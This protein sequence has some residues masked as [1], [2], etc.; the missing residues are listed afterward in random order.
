MSDE[1]SDDDELRLGRLLTW[2]V[3]ANGDHTAKLSISPALDLPVGATFDR[4]INLG[5]LSATSE[6]T[7]YDAFDPQTERRVTITLFEMDRG[8]AADETRSTKAI[9]RR[10]QAASRVRHPHVVEVLDVGTYPSGVFVVTEHLDAI[11]VREWLHQQ[12]PRPRWSRVAAVFRDAGRGLAAAHAHG[13]IHCALTLDDILMTPGGRVCIGG[14]GVHAVRLGPTQASPDPDDPST[15]DQTDELQPAVIATQRFATRSRVSAPEC[16]LGN[17]PSSKSDQFSFCVCFYEALYG[18]HPFEGPNPVTGILHHQLRPQPNPD[19]VPAWLRAVVVHGLAPTPQERHRSMEALLGELDH[20]PV[21]SRR[22]WLKGLTLLAALVALATTAALLI[23]RESTRCEP[24]PMDLDGVWDESIRNRLRTAFQDSGRPYADPSWQTVERRLDDWTAEWQVL[25]ARACELT[26]IRRE[27]SPTLHDRR[28]ACLDDRLREVEAFTH[29]IGIASPQAIEGAVVALEALNRPSSCIATQTLDATSHASS[30]DIDIDRIRLTIDEGWIALHIDNLELATAKRETAA[31]MLS[32]VDAPSLLAAYELM[33]AAVDQDRHDFTK[34][35]KTLHMTAARSAAQD[36]IQPAAQAWLALI[37]NAVER[38]D[39][40]HASLWL[41]HASYAVQFAGDRRLKQQ[42]AEL[43]GDVARLDGRE[44]DALSHYHV[45][46]DA[47]D[48]TLTPLDEARVLTKLGQLIA[49]HRPGPAKPVNEDSEQ[50]VAQRYF[51][52]A[53]TLQRDELGATH[54]HLS[55][56]TEA[57]ATSHLEC[58]AT[59]EAS[60]EFQQMLKIELARPERKPDR[61]AL[62]QLMM[63]RVELKRGRIHTA[64]E[65][66]EQANTTALALDPTGRDIVATTLEVMSSARLA[67]G[68]AELARHHLEDALRIRSQQ[69]DIIAIAHTRARLADVLWQGNDADRRRAIELA[70]LARHTFATTDR[71]VERNA[72]DQWLSAHVTP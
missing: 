2:P 11:T 46:L 30:P 45:A 68:Q 4:Y 70:I 52:R 42:L 7:S 53:L 15:S 22:R 14:W 47:I 1:D 33:A 51:E 72:L 41:E 60:A 56:T 35:D 24:N 64:L 55:P 31:A 8:R 63:G 32:G 59:E 17:P 19:P 37:R 16:L 66:L 23:Y 34:A 38:D 9:L 39:A 27:A 6:Q 57:L 67:L 3:D 50:V 36:L 65:W 62:A 12:S 18:V 25:R 54:P 10:L 29:T 21:A 58:G 49:S 26:W 28:L 13:V 44:G 40:E 5:Q 69:E 43:R 20:D 48:E 71:M 61:I